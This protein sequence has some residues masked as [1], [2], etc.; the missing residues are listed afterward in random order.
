M[1]E[2][3]TE[4]GKYNV[5][6]E[7]VAPHSKVSKELGRDGCRWEDRHVHSQMLF[8]KGQRR[9][10]IEEKLRTWSTNVLLTFNKIF[11]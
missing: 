5:A 4:G 11:R 8:I 1:T 2:I 9:V 6:G 3:E 10:M 7:I